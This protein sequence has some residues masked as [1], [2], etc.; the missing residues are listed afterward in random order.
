MASEGAA[1]FRQLVRA[2]RKG[3]PTLYGLCLLLVRSLRQMMHAYGARTF[4]LQQHAPWAHHLVREAHQ[5]DARA[6]FK[7]DTPA[8]AG[9]MQEIRTHWGKNAGVTDPQQLKV[10]FGE[11]REAATFLQTSVVQGMLNERGNYGALL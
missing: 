3:A 2:A 8:L 7:G 4:A 6:V 9:A 5:I 10:M 1:V 11:G